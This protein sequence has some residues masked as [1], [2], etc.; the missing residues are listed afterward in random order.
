[1]LICLALRKHFSFLEWIINQF[2][3]QLKRMQCTKPTFANNASNY[4]PTAFILLNKSN[5]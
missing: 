1:M 2:F 3:I 4:L 5:H